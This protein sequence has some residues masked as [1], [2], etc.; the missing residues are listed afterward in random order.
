MSSQALELTATCQL[1]D[2]RIVFLRCLGADDAGA[3]VALYQR[4]TDRDRYYCFFTL[5]AVHLDQLVDKMIECGNRPC[6]FGA[7]DG[8]RL[9][10]VAN[11]TVSDDPSTAEIAIVVAH[12]Y[13]SLSVGTALLKRLA[14]IGRARGIRHFE[15]DVLADNDPM[16]VILFDFGWPSK[17][18]NHGS[19]L[20][21][22]IEPP[23][24]SSMA[25]TASKPSVSPAGTNSTRMCMSSD[26]SSAISRPGGWFRNPNVPNLS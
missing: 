24:S 18:L 12:Q 6:A 1:R 10:G 23:D 15:A 2:G 9:I 4:L 26:S 14:Q 16:L 3:V 5:N 20:H 25:S 17:R 7:F 13:H 22:N 21:L 19:V 11:Y 8:E